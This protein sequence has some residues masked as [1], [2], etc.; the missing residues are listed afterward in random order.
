MKQMVLEGS[1]KLT[2]IVEISGSKNSA[3]ALIPATL[4]SDG[5]VELDN[6]PMISDIEAL[7]EILTFL[8]AEIKRDKQK[9]TIDCAKV[10]NK[11]IP[12]QISKKLRASYYFMGALLGK[13]KHVEMYFPGGC[14]IGKRPIDLHLSGFEKLGAKVEVAENKYMVDAKELIG[15][16]IEL[17]IA[18]VGA[19]INLMFAAVYAKGKTRIYNAAK[20][21]HIVNVAELLQQMGAKVSGAGTHTIE[22]EGVEVLKGAQHRVVPDYIE[23]GT[24]VIAGA[25]C[26]ENLEVKNIVPEHIASLINQ[27]KQMGCSLTVLKDSV[28]ISKIENYKSVAVKTEV[29][30]GFPT[31]L[32]QPFMT[33]LSLA[34]GT[35]K[36]EETIFENR[37]MHVPYLNQMGANITIEGQIATIKGVKAFHGS[38]VV[39]TDLRAGA[40]LILAGLVA[41][42]QTVIDGIEHVLRGYENIEEKLSNV[43]AK[44]RVREI[45]LSRV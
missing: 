2:G 29:Y 4:L 18:S 10:S 34:E 44:L 21:P 22:I 23:A 24:Y 11:E 16:D 7:I 39:A 6:V 40:A 42:G 30:P 33:L 8:G 19:T 35:S 38:D 41:E 36:V 25:L 17:P 37:F 31:D 9:M 27:L 45:E 15:T 32:Q 13:Y 28:R 3:V 20:E 26:G 5:I 12:E 1:T 43:G 14:S